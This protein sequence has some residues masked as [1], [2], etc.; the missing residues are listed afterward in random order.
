MCFSINIDNDTMVFFNYRADRMRQITE[1]I[2]MEKFKELNSTVPHPKN[3]ELY[4]MT[5]YNKEVFF[6]PFIKTK[7]L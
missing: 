1:C 4:G 5:Q 6:N 3:I 7:L 2:G